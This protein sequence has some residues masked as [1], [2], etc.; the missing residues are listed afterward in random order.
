MKRTAPAKKIPARLAAKLR[1]VRLFIVDVDG[2]LTDGSINLSA[3]DETKRFHIADGL[4]LKLLMN[5]G[6]QVAILTGRSSAA[7]D[8]RAAE[9]GVNLVVQDQP[10]KGAAARKLIEDT[11]IESAAVAAMGDDLPDLAV[12]DQC[13]VRLAVADAAPELRAEADWVSSRPGGHAAVREAAELILKA[14]GAWDDLVEAL[15]KERS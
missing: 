3:N 11:G 10:D 8:R 13:G 2:T 15:R 9:L 6:V 4:G 1:A 5:A 12:F 7:V 14:K